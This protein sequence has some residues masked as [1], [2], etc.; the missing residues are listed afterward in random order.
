LIQNHNI[1][2]ANFFIKLD[3]NAKTKKANTITYPAAGIINPEL[4]YKNDASAWGLLGFFEG[5]KLLFSG[6]FKKS[7][8]SRQSQKQPNE[9]S[10]IGS[11]DIYRLFSESAKDAW[12]NARASAQKRGSEVGVEDI[13]LALLKQPSVKN[14]LSRIK[15][16]TASAEIF[17][18]NYLKLT[19]SAADDAL[20]IIPF[21]A[22]S[23]A[24]KLHN[25]KIGSLM[26]LGALLEASPQNNILQAIFSNIG[27]TS[28]QLEVFAVWL[29]K[30]NYNFPK[31]SHAAKVL[32]CL[33]QAQGL[34]Q[35]F[36][37]FFE[38]SAVEQAVKLSSGQTLIDLEHQKSLQLLVR[39]AGLAKN[40]GSKTISEHL[41]KQAAGK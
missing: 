13:F 12:K 7:L 33:N 5:Y 27:L 37:Y 4:I 18:S 31:N 25:N 26:L 29:L 28:E 38:Y 17:L 16:S 1:T 14:L 10:I 20:K 39:A 24:I 9:N 36:G 23:L 2:G 15:V 3:M 6:A 35:H 41:V 30:L 40:T 21:E 8:S 19:P 34:E 32:Y 22:F 11:V